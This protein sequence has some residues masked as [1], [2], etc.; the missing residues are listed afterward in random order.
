MELKKKLDSI[1]TTELTYVAA[2]IVVLSVAALGLQ[3]QSSNSDMSDEQ[4]TVS[5]KLDM[6]DSNVSRE[7]DLEANSTAF[8]ALNKSFE[9]NY[10]EYDFGYFVTSINGVSQNQTHSWVYLINGE[11]ANKAVNNYYLSE[12]DNVTFSYTSENLFE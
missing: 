11:T 9:I 6:S 4:V 10:T 1:E 5:L 2:G 12:G 7:V 8:D 3:Y